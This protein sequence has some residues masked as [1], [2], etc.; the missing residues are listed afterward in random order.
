MTYHWRAGRL[1]DEGQNIFV[2]MAGAGF[3][4]VFE[5]PFWG[6][7]LMLGGAV[8]LLYSIKERLRKPTSSSAVWLT[9]LLITWAAIGYDYYDRR[10]A[11][12]AF[13]DAPLVLVSDKT[14]MNEEVGIDGK[15]FVRCTFTNVKFVFNGTAGSA[16][17][18]C[19]FLGSRILSSKNRAVGATATLIMGLKFQ[20]I[21]SVDS[22]GVPHAVEFNYRSEPNK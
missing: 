19:N 12:F 1:A 10:Q 16:F 8:G 13:S 22:N 11:Q 15:R 6:T 14:F 7:V 4:V 9:A 5:H 20:S 2:A 17:D 21:V 18:S 3:F